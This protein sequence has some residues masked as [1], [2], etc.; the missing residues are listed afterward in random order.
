MDDNNSTLEDR[1]IADMRHQEFSEILRQQRELRQL[2]AGMNGRAERRQSSTSTITIEDIA[3]Q[4]AVAPA[5]TRY[6]WTE[7]K[8]GDWMMLIGALG[9]GFIGAIGAE[10]G[11]VEVKHSEEKNLSDMTLE[12]LEAIAQ[13]KRN[14]EM[15]RLCERVSS[16]EDELERTKRELEDACISR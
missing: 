10:P 2:V 9:Y 6:E 11:Q 1:L 4:Y 15:R 13:N 3:A 16:L 14:K 12:E 8:L 7:P 5:P